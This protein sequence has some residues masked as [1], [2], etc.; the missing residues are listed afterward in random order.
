[1]DYKFSHVFLIYSFLG[2]LVT[3]S[4]ATS[5]PAICAVFE[6]TGTNQIFGRILASTS[7]SSLRLLHSSTPAR[8]FGLV[9]PAPPRSLS[10]TRLGYPSRAVHRPRLMRTSRSP[11]R[12]RRVG[13]IPPQAS[14]QATASKSLAKCSVLFFLSLH[15]FRT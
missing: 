13:P 9:F 7:D 12:P 2:S 3:A 10:S 11:S 15:R 8:P 5:P 6:G 1:M 14:P 4:F